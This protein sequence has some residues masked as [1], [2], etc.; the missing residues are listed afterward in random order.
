MFNLIYRHTFVGV[1]WHLRGGNRVNL[2]NINFVGLFVKKN[3]EGAK[4]KKK[5]VFSPLYIQLKNKN[6]K[7]IVF[8]FYLLPI[9]Q[10]N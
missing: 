4:C 1:A 10:S 5:F 8:M 2:T 9:K 7:T 3:F 6:Y